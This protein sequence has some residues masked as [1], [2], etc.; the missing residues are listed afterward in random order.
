[1]DIEK[2][3]YDYMNYLIIERQLSSNT[4]DAYKRDLYSFFNY[5]NKGYKSVNKNDVINYITSLDMNPKSINRHIVTLK[6]YFNFLEKNSMLSINP[7]EDIQGLKTKKS[8]KNS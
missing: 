3:I 1:M 6:N 2:E 8:I 4:I 5:V 7:M